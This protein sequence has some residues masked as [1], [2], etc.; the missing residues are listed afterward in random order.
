MEP[1]ILKIGYGIM[2]LGT[3]IIRYP[4]EKRNKSNQIITNK[5]ATLEKILLGLVFLG[6]MILPLIYIFSDLFSFAD[7]TLPVSFHVLGFLLIVPNLWLFYKSH[8]DLGMNWSVSLEIRAGHNIVDTGVY[9]YVRHPMYTA[10]W[11]GCVAQALLLN[12]YIAGLSGL[13]CFG[14]LYFFRFKKEEHMM[15]QE[16]GQDY[17]EYM[18]KTKRIIPFIY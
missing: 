8:K 15:L 18:K 11:I 7:Y 2:V 17:E 13:V 12:N 10:I 5:K 6:M 4:H 3:S 14:L 16:F 9:K 1:I